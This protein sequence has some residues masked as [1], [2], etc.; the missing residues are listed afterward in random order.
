MK[1][2]QWLNHKDN[3]LSINIWENKYRRNEET[4][5]EWLN[6]VSAGDQLLHKLI[7]E[8]KLLLGGRTFAN[9]GLNNGASF[10][11]CY[12]RGYIEDDYKSIMQAATEIG[13]TFK[14]QGGQ[15]IS[16]SHLRPK[17]APIGKEY[18]SDGIIPFMRIYNE[19]TSGTS[20]GGSRKGALMISL[21]A[22]HKEAMNF[23]TI[24]SQE[25]VIEKANLS[26]EIDNE[27]M[28]A[29]EKFYSTGEVVVLHEKREYSGHAIEYDIVP[30]EIFKALVDNCY[31][32]GDPAALFVDR[33][34]NYNL[35]ECDDEYN[36]E[37]CNPCGEQPLP[38]HGACCLASINLSKFV[39]NPYTSDAWLDTSALVEAIAVGIKTLD[40]L[41]D[42]NAANHPLSEQRQMSIDWRNVGLGCCGYA[43][44]L[45]K[46]G[47]RYG[48]DEAIAF[49]D[50]LFGF[51]FR[52]AVIASNELAKELGPFPKYKDCLWDSEIIRNHFSAEDIERMKPYGLRNCSLLSVAPTGSIATMVKESGGC[53]PEFA[54]SYTRKTESLD[55][56]DDGYYKV[57]CRAAEEYQNLYNT[58]NFPDCFVTSEDIPWLARVKTQ[59]AMQKHVDTAISS[60][61]NLPVS[62]TKEDI[63]GIYL[64]SWKHGIKGITIFRSGCKR[65][66]ILS[67]GTSAS[68]KDNENALPRGRV[69]PVSEKVIGK[70]RKLVTG[71][72][73]LHAHIDF[74]PE[75]GNLMGTFLDKGSTGGCNNFM[76]GLSRMISLTARAGVSVPDI[77]DQLNSTGVCSSYAV[78][79]ATKR[80]TSKGACCPMA[81][82]NALMDAW[83]EMQSE[84][85]DRNATPKTDDK[86]TVVPEIRHDVCPECSEPLIHEGGCDICKN[87]GWSK[88]N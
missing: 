48:S 73:T 35:M 81:V 54:L 21:D 71:C 77:V 12:S 6:R 30:I 63:A 56:G 17:G 60:T 49:T 36:I 52:A 4:F 14:A 34:R 8:Q 57:Y 19:V 13:L 59:A 53:E 50:S 74:D 42:E 15:G 5:N 33:F 39:T 72:G 79:R 38:K 27:F 80:D 82:G 23:I 26:L 47:Y 68:L 62:A 45:M 44:M 32:W 28:E 78:R 86:K 3:Q 41:I 70:Y 83:K 88:C 64:E 51:I 66:P 2:E 1:V 20:Q 29:V 16:L 87:C 43:T 25:G 69:V 9:R 85:A 84:I 67:S 61:I 37:T 40:K 76:I 55:G 10:F 75:T 65:A 31:D 24:K 46:L 7:L 58:T 11:N 22:R 18:T